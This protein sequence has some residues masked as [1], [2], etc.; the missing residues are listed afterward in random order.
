MNLKSIG[1]QAAGHYPKQLLSGP[2]VIQ[3]IGVRSRYHG[4]PY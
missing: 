4:H 2:I 3:Y 1:S